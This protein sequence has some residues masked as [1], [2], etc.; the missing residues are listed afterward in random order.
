MTNPPPNASSANS[1]DSRATIPPRLVEPQ[2]GRRAGDVRDR[3][4]GRDLDGPRQQ[5]EHE[6]H[7]DADDGVADDHDA[8]GVRRRGPGVERRL[9]DDARG[10]RPAAPSRPTRRPGTARTARSGR[11]AST[12][13][14][15]DACSM[16]RNGPTSLPLGLSTPSVAA[17]SSTGN[18]VLPANTMPGADH[19]QRPE[20]Q[21]PPAAEPVGAR[22]Q[23]QRDR[24]VAEQRQGEEQ[25]DLGRRRSRSPRGTARGRPRGS[26]SRT[27]AGSGS[28]TAARRRG[29]ACLRPPDHRA[30]HGGPAFRARVRMRPTA[31]TAPRPLT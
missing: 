8:V 3:R 6:R 10:E 29:W 26:R 4:R 24:G 11:R 13:C 16:A 18:A 5:R 7:R 19:Q 15:S 21:R 20:E 30:G 1:A 17:T 27:S 28:R 12:S 14:E 23:Q 9:R 31:C 2:P 25:A 22:R